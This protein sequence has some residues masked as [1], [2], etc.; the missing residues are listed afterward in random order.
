MAHEIVNRLTAA[1]H[2]DGDGTV[3]ASYG[4]GSITRTGLG[5]YEFTADGIQ[6][7][8]FLAGEDVMMVSARTNQQTVARNETLFP[9]G[10]IEVLILSTDGKNLED[11]P[12]DIIVMNAGLPS[13]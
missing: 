13:V 2:V 6:K 11:G 5:T 9:G 7:E 8:V 1:A 3:F 4:F 10:T 12:F